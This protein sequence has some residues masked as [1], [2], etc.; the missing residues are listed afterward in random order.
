M[1]PFIFTEDPF[2]A[3]EAQLRKQEGPVPEPWVTGCTK[4]SKGEQRVK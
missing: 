2:T 3:V 1:V 4:V